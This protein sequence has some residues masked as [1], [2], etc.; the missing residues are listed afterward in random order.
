[1]TGKKV[2]RKKG[3]AKGPR[4]SPLTR[5]EKIEGAKLWR[6][7]VEARLNNHEVKFHDFHTR[8]QTA[9]SVLSDRVC[10]LENV[11]ANREKRLDDLR[12]EV[13]HFVKA[14]V[15]PVETPRSA[16]PP[17]APYHSAIATAIQKLDQMTSKQ[18]EWLIREVCQRR[19]KEIAEQHEKQR[20]QVP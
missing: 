15:P 3:P 11:L 5:A 20:R 1:M 12:N 13:F 10:M 18:A 9:T 4:P 16:A 7:G 14:N 2:T 19:G 6:G 8:L 17:V